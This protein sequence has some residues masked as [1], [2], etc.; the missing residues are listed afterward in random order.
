[1]VLSMCPDAPSAASKPPSSLPLNAARESRRD[2]GSPLD[3]SALSEEVYHLATVAT[4]KTGF[5]VRAMI[6]LRRTAAAAP[7]LAAPHR[8]GPCQR[9]R[10]QP[11]AAPPRRPRSAPR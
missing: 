2:A 10:R 8:D 7:V 1:M 4:A 9:G 6:D 11:R 3:G 5:G